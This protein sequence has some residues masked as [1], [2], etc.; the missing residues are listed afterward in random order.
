[1]MVAYLVYLVLSI[2]ALAHPSRNLA[3]CYIGFPPYITL[4][5]L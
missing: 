4:S 3:R 5:R 1:M 2:Q